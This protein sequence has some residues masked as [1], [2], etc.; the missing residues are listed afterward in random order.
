MNVFWKI[1][2]ADAYIIERC[3]VETQKRFAFIGQLVFVIFC[4]CIISV[5]YAMHNIFKNDFEATLIAIFVA[6]T[7]CNIYLLMLGTLSKNV[8]P[9]R[10]D[11]KTS[12]LASNLFRL[13]YLI[14]IAFIISKPLEVAISQ[15]FL[16][17]DI[18]LEKQA[19]FK[20]LSINFNNLDE[21]KKAIEIAV[22]QKLINDSDYTITQIKF[23]CTKL[24][25][26]YSWLITLAVVFIF[27]LP[28]YLKFNISENK[29]YYI[30]K[31]RVERHIIE[32]EYED[33]KKTYS[34]IFHSKHNVTTIYFEYYEDAPYNT[35]VK[36]N[37]IYT[38]SENDF[39]KE[40][41]GI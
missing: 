22:I 26:A 3:E 4:L 17:E 40:V 6:F 33:F 28:A 27:L 29:Y 11:A 30:E 2:G 1:S 35:K 31:K 41:Y 34:Q 16:K 25:Y 36:E 9:F 23:L 14:I 7:I 10:F 32:S 18:K 21:T 15:P 24:K 37:K 12:I 20:E 38:H 5:F 8:L 39:I 13:S 19:K